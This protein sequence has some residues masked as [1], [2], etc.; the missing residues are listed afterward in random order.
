MKKLSLTFV[1]GLLLALPIIYL[2]QLE[3]LGAITLVILLSIGLVF[4]LT[5]AFS[6]LIGKKKQGG[7]SS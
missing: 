2:L 3:G 7:A 1:V 4:L 6:A 5:A